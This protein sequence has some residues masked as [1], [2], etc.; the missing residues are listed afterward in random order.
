MDRDR[1]KEFVQRNREE[2]DDLELPPLAFE[3]LKQ[4]MLPA[5]KNRAKARKL[6]LLFWA[7][8]AIVTIAVFGTLIFF[9]LKKDNAPT[10]QSPSLASARDHRSQPGQKDKLK[11]EINKMQAK[12]DITAQHTAKKIGSI[13]QASAEFKSP[14]TDSSSVSSRLSAVLNTGNSGALSRREIS[15]LCKTLDYDESS[16][17]RLAA[18]DRLSR[19]LSPKRLKQIAVKSLPRQQNPMVQFEMISFLTAT[20]GENPQIVS[21]AQAIAAA[22]DIEDV[23]RDQALMILMKENIL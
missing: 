15:A 13:H 6:P 2:F 20:G 23:V 17:V 16:N 18:F 5:G 1:L 12:S 21:T 19:S 3:R 8:A 10:V 11:W 14:L 22:P 7:S 9:N 4:E